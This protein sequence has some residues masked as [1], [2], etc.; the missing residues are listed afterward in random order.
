MTTTTETTK[1]VTLTQGEWD[2]IRCAL[3]CYVCDTREEFPAWANQ[4]RQLHKR[5]RAETLDS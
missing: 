1:T 2:S 3:I 4:L 5:L